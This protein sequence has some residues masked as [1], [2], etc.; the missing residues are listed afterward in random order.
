VRCGHRIG[1][2]LRA[3]PAALAAS[4]A[5]WW[6][7]RDT[8]GAH[9]WLTSENAHAFGGQPELHALA[10]S[11]HGQPLA[12]AEVAVCLGLASARGRHDGG[13]DDDYDGAHPSVA[14][15]GRP[16]G[17]RLASTGSVRGLLLVLCRWGPWN[18]DGGLTLPSAAATQR[19]H[20]LGAYYY[21]YS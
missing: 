2:R 19:K 6:Q 13:D 14:G 8:S 17:A 18:D 20:S 15:R 7:Q 10:R 9:Q 12:R 5:C 11:T 21:L 3:C 4:A 1:G 16:T